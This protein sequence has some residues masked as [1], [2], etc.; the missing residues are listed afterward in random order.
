[1]D[2]L[3]KAPA[4]LES[5]RAYLRCQGGGGE[6]NFYDGWMKNPMSAMISCNEGRNFYY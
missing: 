1:M 5:H 6:G 3:P 4:I 2:F